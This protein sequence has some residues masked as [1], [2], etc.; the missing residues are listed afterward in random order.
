MPTSRRLVQQTLAFDAPARIPRNPWTLDWAGIHYPRELE[1]ITRS[2]PSDI[3]GAP[4][5]LRTPPPTSGSETEIGTFRDEWGCTFTNIQRG[6]IGEVHQPLV[7]NWSDL[8][9]VKEPL[10]RLSVDV[11]QVNAFCRASDQFVTGGTCPR[12]FERLQFLRGSQNLYLDLAEESPEFFTLLDK[13]HNFYIKELELWATTEVD[14]LNFM[15][16]W[17]AQRRLLISPRQWRRIFKPL[18]KTYVEI[19]HTHGKKIFMHSDGHIFD[20]YPDLI[21]IGVDAINSQLFCMDIEKIGELYAG[22][23]TFWGEIDR[24]HL[25]PAATPAEIDVAVRRVYRALYRKG[26]VIAQCEFGAGAR[27]ENVR[28]VYQSWNDLSDE[29]H[30]ER[31]LTDGET[32]V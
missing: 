12:P 1:E 31:V 17:G 2:F 21:E 22:Q 8:E 27:P 29:S 10:G 26:G 3:A 28:Q 16:D 25:L 32:L 7:Q 6:V 30:D 13:V 24:Q 5:F 4:A 11:E 23:I 15:D 9:R 18:Y 20:I 14:A 19:A